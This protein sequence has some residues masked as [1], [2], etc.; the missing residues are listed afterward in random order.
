MYS[1]GETAP[2]YT[3]GDAVKMEGKCVIDI[4]K[5]M[6]LDTE[7]EVKVSIFPGG[8]MME[9]KAKA[10]NFS[11]DGPEQFEVPVA[12]WFLLIFVCVEIVSLHSLYYHVEFVLYLQ[13]RFLQV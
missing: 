6:R 1:S 7:R 10:V 5:D 13:M 4:S 2:R 3:I 12:S 9:I 11:V 8:S